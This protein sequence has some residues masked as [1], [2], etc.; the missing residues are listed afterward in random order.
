MN[1]KQLNDEGRD[2]WN[3][4]AVFWDELH[5]DEGNLFHRTL[6]EPSVETLLDLQP[7]ERVLDIGCGNGVLARRL[8]ELGGVVTAFDFSEALINLAKARGQKSGE[9]ID[10]RVM[11]AT[12]KEAMV[13]LGEGKFDVITCTMTLMDVPTIEPIFRAVRQLLTDDGRF[14]YSTAHPAFNSNNPIFVHEKVDVDGVV[15]DHY[16]VKLRTYLDMPPV[17]GSGA[18]DEPNPHYYYHRPLHELLGVAFANGLVLDG[19]L[20][21][22]FKPE[23]ADRTD[24][25]DWLKLWQIPP[26][27]TGRLRKAK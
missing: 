26:V 8:A 27:I 13:S 3:G 16:A 14:V 7:G 15:S 23:D 22:A 6:I 24:R 10:Y 18:P 25:L 1:T 5:G 20:E 21:P 11:D 4:K 12:D 17:K 2:L 19:L 9:P